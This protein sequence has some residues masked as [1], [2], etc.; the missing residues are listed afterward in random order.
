[1]VQVLFQVHL[2]GYFD[3]ARCPPLKRKV[4]IEKK[5]QKKFKASQN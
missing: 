4:G 5:R 2:G 3:E 1:V